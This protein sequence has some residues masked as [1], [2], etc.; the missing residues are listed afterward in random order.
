M[1]GGNIQGDSVRHLVTERTHEEH[2]SGCPSQQQKLKGNL[3]GYPW[4][5]PNCKSLTFQRGWL[6]CS[7]LTDSLSSFSYSRVPERSNITI[8]FS[9]EYFPS[10]ISSLVL[11]F[12]S[13]PLIYN[14]AISKTLPSPTH[15]GL[16][17]LTPDILFHSPCWPNT[18]PLFNFP[19]PTSVTFFLWCAVLS[20]ASK[21]L[22][23]TT[24]FSLLALGVPIS[25]S[26]QILL[27]CCKAS[28]WRFYIC[29]MWMRCSSSTC[30][31]TPSHWHFLLPPVWEQ[32]RIPK[33]AFSG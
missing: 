28:S 22:P 29:S 5:P 30:Y 13:V 14:L 11:L 8:A 20:P 25:L 2:F 16:R 32:P 19:A 27:F 1:K 24:P 31:I 23:F 10:W 26:S 3:A 15:P 4:S 12:S 6:Q 7:C 9:S 33:R 18:L 21:H 17:S